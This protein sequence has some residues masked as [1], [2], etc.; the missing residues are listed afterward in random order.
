MAK[1]EQSIKKFF[2][3]PDHHADKQYITIMSMETSS[4]VLYSITPEARVPVLGHGHISQNAS[5]SLKVFY[6]PVYHMQILSA[7]LY[8][9]EQ[10]LHICEIHGLLG[11][12]S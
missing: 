11:Q 3:T 2:S 8:Q 5:F 6:T 9:I 1:I 10:L 7:Y 12:G 4:N